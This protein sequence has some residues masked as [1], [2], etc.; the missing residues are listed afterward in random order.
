MKKI[1]VSGCLFLSIIQ[2]VNGQKLDTVRYASPQ[3]LH[4]KYMQNRKTQNKT[5]L[6]IL[7]CGLGMTAGGSYIYFI[8]AM[9]EGSITNTGPTLF[10]LGAIATLASVPFFISAGQNKK[11]AKLALKEEFL[12]I[13]NRI[14]NRSNYMA[15]ALT[16]RL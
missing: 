11:K 6:I 14:L 5:G 7:T 1:L 13:G 9:G 10:Y 2:L 3:E 15:L 4:E 8:Q 16:I 12:T